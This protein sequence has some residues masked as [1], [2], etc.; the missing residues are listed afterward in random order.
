MSQLIRQAAAQEILS[1]FGH[2]EARVK[3][4]GV[5]Y[6]D[7]VTAA[8]LAAST[9]ILDRIRQ[10]FPGSYS[11]EH[12]YPDR[13]DHDLIW[14]IDPL[15]GTDEFCAQ[16]KAGFACQ[17]A[18]LQRQT[19]GAYTPMAGIIYLPG[20]D[21]LWS[22]D[23]QNI[24]YQLNGQALPL[25][26]YSRESISGWI[27]AV[28][29][30]LRLPQVY[31]ALGQQLRVPVTLVQGGGSGASLAALLAGRIN[32]I[33]FN[34]N[35]SKEWDIAM[36]E[37]LLRACGGWLCDL[38]GNNFTYNRPDSVGYG[39]PYNLRGYVASI[40]FQQQHIVPYLPAG[41]L[42]DRL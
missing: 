3:T 1:R 22:Y 11:E 39:E 35:Y 30:S 25:P 20:S 10:S 40:A 34:F 38:D 27:R 12:K 9:F 37:P 31:R 28:D 18:L 13:F 17:A 8:D 24:V 41:I 14:Q 29:P 19:S 4:A 6:R 21:E 15:D 32:L 7:S 23:G 2:V 26:Q 5:H 36:A 16:M 33:I 42:E